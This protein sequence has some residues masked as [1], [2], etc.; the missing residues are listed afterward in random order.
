MAYDGPVIK[1]VAAWLA[2]RF[3]GAPIEHN[4]DFDRETYLFR[5]SLGP[6]RH[7]ELELSREV[8]DRQDAPQVLSELEREDVA[9]RMSRDPTLRVQFFD[10][11][12]RGFETRIVQCD[13]R[14]YRVVRDKQHNVVIYD[15]KGRRLERSPQSMHVLQG[16][17]FKRDA[18]KWCE[19][20]LQSRGPAQ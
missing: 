14:L 19:E 9:A 4:G 16:S 17:I 20:I 6:A 10:D 5:V 8:T 2:Q 3:P 12:I 1:A 13:G 15:A 11:G 7:P 18:A